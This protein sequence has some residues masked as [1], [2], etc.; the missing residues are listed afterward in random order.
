[1]EVYMISHPAELIRAD[2]MRNWKTPEEIPDSSDSVDG[3]KSGL[4]E[5]K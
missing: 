2:D 3:T 4:Q 1:M 5:M